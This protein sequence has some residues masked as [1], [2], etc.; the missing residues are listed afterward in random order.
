MKALCRIA[1]MA[2]AQLI[3][4]STVTSAVEIFSAGLQV[5][6][7]LSLAPISFGMY[8]G[9]Y[10][11]PDPGGGASQLWIVPPS[12]GAPVAVANDT[13][14]G[15]AMKDWKGGMFLPADYGVHGGKYLMTTQYG[16]AGFD[17]SGTL[18]TITNQST[19]GFAG[20]GFLIRPSAFTTPG[21][22]PNA[23]GSNGGKVFATYQSTEYWHSY[24]LDPFD[25]FSELVYEFQFQGDGGIGV[26]NPN[27]TYQPFRRVTFSDTGNQNHSAPFGMTWSPAEFGDFDDRLLVS[28]ASSGDIVALD[29]TGTQ[30]DFTQIALRPGERGLRQM[31]FVPEGFDHLT[32]LLLVS[33]SGSQ[34]GGG[35]LGRLLALTASGQIAYELRLGSEFDKFDPRGVAFTAD[36]RILVNDASDPIYIFDTDEFVAVPEPSS[37]AL[38]SLALV[39]L[40]WKCRRSRMTQI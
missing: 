37:F 5:P 10:F 25:P 31:S 15:F 38:L 23:F 29:E 26:L 39:A 19:L 30:S 24:P 17:S 20:D 35:A 4:I 11:V 33:V 3:V 14:Q 6:E 2:V 22:A 36:G 40:G 27:G 21:M 9:N 34:Q 12:G 32:G 28:S 13:A 1:L 18:S 8:G 16:L 7:T